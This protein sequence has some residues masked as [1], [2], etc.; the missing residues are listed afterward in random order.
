MDTLVRLF[1]IAMI[2]L[3]V[4]NAMLYYKLRRIETLA[5]GIRSD[6]SLASRLTAPVHLTRPIEPP[7]QI[8][9]PLGN[10]N[11]FQQDLTSWRDVISNTLT[12]IQKM[13]NSLK[14]WDKTLEKRQEPG[15]EL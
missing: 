10:R 5:D 1:I 2:C 13:E 9:N 12:V 14:E 4:I 8:P 3:M 6:P 7:E 15:G 11:N